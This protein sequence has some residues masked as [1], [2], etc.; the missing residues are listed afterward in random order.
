MA[1][2]SPRVRLSVDEHVGVLQLADH[3]SKNALSE[4]LVH[5]LY[6][7]LADVA[8]DTRIHALVLSGL[9]E[10]FCAGASLPLLR[11]VVHGRVAP[12]DILLGKAILELPV[13]V[14]AALEGHAVGGGFALGLCADMVILARESRYGANFMNMGFTPGMGM[15]RLLEQVMSPAQA[16]ELLF[17][18]EARKGADFGGGAGFNYILPRREVLPKALDLAARIAEKP[19][20]TLE[21][22]KRTLALPR[23]QAFAATH[24]L[25]SLMHE[26]SFAQADA[27][28]LIEENYDQ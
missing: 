6:A 2:S 19:R 21:L 8:A 25:E 9:P 17:T 23:R 5:E 10:V 27:G 22:L 1:L 20:R 15:T 24:T 11:A 18:G 14:V 28:R 12:T 7:R 16:R 13:P 3:A 4:E 26:V